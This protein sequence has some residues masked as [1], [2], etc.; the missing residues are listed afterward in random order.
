MSLVT[1]H[2][3]DAGELDAGQV[4]DEL[5]GLL[6][7]EPG[8]ER[9]SFAEPPE[10]LIGGFETLTFAV[11]LSEALTHLSGPM[12]LR[13]LAEPGG[14]RQAAKEAA[15]QNGAAAAGYP[16][17]R[18]LLAGRERTIGGRAFNLMERVAGHSM[19]EA[20]FEDMS[21]GPEIADLLARTHADLHDMPSDRIASA[22]E[23]AGI[24][25]R[26]LNLAG[27]LDTLE[28]YIADAT[29]AHLDEGVAWLLKNQP[30]ER[31]RLAVCHGDFH[32]GNVMV[33][34]GEVT[35]VIDWS[36]AQLADPEYDVAVSL[37]LVAVAAPE[38]A[39]DL[40]PEAFVAF[41]AGYLDSYSRRRTLDPKRV[42]YYRAFRAMRAFLR[43]TA[44]RT[45][46]V[47]L[48]L[49][50]RDGYPW[51]TEGALRRVA[52]VIQETTAIAMPLPPGVEPA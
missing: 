27:Q 31:D 45:P 29:L 15:F 19:M 42:G 34:S 46:R 28:G 21:L 13:L 7:I 2:A 25:L 39:G 32:P 24:P 11:R 5:L 6:R 22:I 50:P 47:N 16:A 44:A 49:M 36:G 12:V 9:A 52:G 17:P 20:M 1:F 41:A 48:G 33:D 30:V 8:M 43:G 40:P 18:V 14:I 23:E 35:G 3:P 38:V 51:A 37:V 26:A 4:A 10:R